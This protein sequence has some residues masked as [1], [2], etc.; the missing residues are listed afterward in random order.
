MGGSPGTAEGSGISYAVWATLNNVKGSP[1]DD[2]D[3]DDISNY[4]EFLF[5]SKPNLASDA[6]A[7][8]TGL[9]RIGEN[10]YL[11]ITFRRN[12]D[13]EGLL[14]LELSGDLATWSSS[15]DLFETLSITDNG[16]NT[17]TITIRLAN[18][19]RELNRQ[20]FLRMRGS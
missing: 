20:V 19:V 1:K 12:M 13:A 10:D 17:S 2:D 16:D 14:E 15:P 9:T 6:P 3:G 11:T 7:P 4:L 5:G 18:P 8:T